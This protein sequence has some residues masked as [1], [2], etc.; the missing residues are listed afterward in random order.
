MTQL[1]L[2]IVTLSF[3]T[4]EITDNCLIK[5]KQASDYCQKLLKNTVRAIVVDNGSSDS[6]V[7]TIKNKHPNVSLVELSKNLG[8]SRGNNIGMALADTPFIL[9][10]NSDTFL[11]K[12][13]LYESLHFMKENPEC[14]VMCCKSVDKNGQYWPDGGH[15][16]TP[17]NTALWALGLEYIPI[18]KNHLPKIYGYQQKFYSQLGFPEWYP[19]CF[20][21][22]KKEVF[23]TT[24][25]FDDQ[26]FLYMEDVEWC[27]RIHQAGYKIW[28]NPQI[29]V[30]H[31]G[32][33]STKKLA[34]LELLRQELTGIVHFQKKH[35]RNFWPILRMVLT[36]GMCL[37]SLFYLLTGNFLKAG[38]YIKLL[39]TVK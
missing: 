5:V 25:G 16:P 15:L 28:Y 37:R 26:L 24:G 3:N 34:T 4:S 14:S 29:Q 21:L 30:T 1:D 22:I 11:N 10:I 27:Q 35:Y 8:Y 9:L 12:D 17:R 31:L 33:S 18:I 23:I 38:W 13:T 6:S 36:I 20:F 32:G 19:T 7:Q 2:S 39:Q